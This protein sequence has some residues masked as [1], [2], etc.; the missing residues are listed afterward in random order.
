MGQRTALV[1]GSEG[2]IGSRISRRLAELDWHVTRST[3]EQ[4]DLRSPSV[5]WLH[6]LPKMDY[7]F[8]CAEFGGI[9]ECKRNQLATHTVNVLGMIRVLEALRDT[10]TAPV[11]L[12]SNMVFPGERVDDDE[13][14]VRDP[15]TSY[16]R[17]KLK[18][19]DYIR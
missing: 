4:L 17:Q 3:K 14:D 10:M 6:A 2:F 15:Q 18:V 13:S 9:V 8:C 5:D 7:V 12:S 1:I 11:Y 19:E 16:G